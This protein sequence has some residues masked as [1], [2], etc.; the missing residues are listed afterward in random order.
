MP[1]VSTPVTFRAGISANDVDLVPL[2]NSLDAQTL[3]SGL[4]I[5][6]ELGEVPDDARRRLVELAARRPAMSVVDAGSV[7]A[8]EPT[9]HDGQVVT[10]G[11]DVA[12]GRLRLFADAL[13]RLSTFATANDCD[14]VL[15]RV[16]TPNATTAPRSLLEASTAV[17]PALAASLATTAI[18]LRRV[19]LGAVAEGPPSRAGVLGGGPVA[20][21]PAEAAPSQSPTAPV[22]VRD[23]AGRW[24]Q[25]RLHVDAVVDGDGPQLIGVLLRDRRTGAE[26]WFEDVST[27]PGEGTGPLEVALDL[28]VVNVA[29]GAAPAAGEWNV[30]L[31]V[32]F[33]DEPD[34]ARFVALPAF[35]LSCVLA[36]GV[37]VCAGATGGE[38]ALDFGGARTSP[39]MGLA[40][41]DADVAESVHGS[42][43]TLRVPGLAVHGHSRLPGGVLL[44]KF[45]LPAVLVGDD[46]GAHVEAR[47][48]G[49]AGRSP[50]AT[51]F[52]TRR[53]VPTGLDLVISP[54]GFMSVDVAAPVEAATPAA[55]PKTAAA[56]PKAASPKPKA[57]PSVPPPAP[58]TLA[59][60]LRRR[61][62]A[63][64]EP[65]A[66]SLAR[67]PT[68]R[69]LYS[70]LTR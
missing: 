33:A 31:A 35:E 47:L 37:L 67:N 15:G 26:H 4:Q 40:P 53:P 69:R 27:H 13:E 24:E 22:V 30:V 65:V 63:P 3:T 50:L 52:G 51:T 23:V 20:I 48:S 41:S 54:T 21:L 66:R 43:L 42:L 11:A 59:K 55:K 34:A 19:S 17:D 25:G 62:P 70:R 64:L 10:V 29:G 38:L 7:G 36:N 61:V 58:P 57:K 46:D 39:V 18:V 14:L 6:W 2:V 60:R 56:K 5:I 28:D 32:A 12:S 45:R 9:L 44:G 16:G 68:A 49:L 1:V 8:G